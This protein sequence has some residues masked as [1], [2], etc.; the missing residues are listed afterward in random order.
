MLFSVVVPV[1]N[2]ESYLT[3][4][5]AS[6]FSQS[7]SDFEVVVI[8][9]GSTDGSIEILESFIHKHP[10]LRVFT[11]ENAGVT[12]ARQRGLYHSNGE[13][14]V[15][16]D[17]DD[18]IN[19]DLLLHLNQC[20][21]QHPGI[22]LIRYCVNMINDA[23]GFDSNVYNVDLSNMHDVVMTGIEALKF[24]TR[25]NKKNDAFWMYAIKR[26]NMNVLFSSPDLKTNGDFAIVP[27]IIAQAKTVVN[28]D[29][30]GYNFTADNLK[31]L[32]HSFGETAMEKRSFD[33]LSAY[34]FIKQFFRSYG[35]I[36]NEDFYFIEDNFNSRLMR[37]LSV[38][39]EPL[40]TKMRSHFVAAMN[41]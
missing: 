15:S 13:Y 8:D 37:R 23:P 9:D 26:S 21:L 19:E 4:C 6:I 3:D 2:A 16:V 31:S 33:L 7:F 24:W 25:S 35:Q 12:R 29:Y 18:T 40:Q 17:S 41:S 34:S 28:I 39:Q 22:E 1:Y 30:C 32:T 38:L 14:I 10:N 11:Y 5:L 27:M 20:I 36:I